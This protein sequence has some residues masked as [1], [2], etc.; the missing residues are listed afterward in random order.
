VKVEQTDCDDVSTVRQVTTVSTEVH[1]ATDMQPLDLTK[2]RVCDTDTETS[3]SG[4]H[5]ALTTS[6]VVA[7]ILLLKGQRY[8]ILPVGGGRWVSRSEYELVSALQKESH[9]RPSQ[10]DDD[11]ELAVVTAVDNGFTSPADSRDDALD[12][13]NANTR[14]VSTCDRQHRDDQTSSM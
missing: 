8:E 2:R 10:T 3:S 14:D 5:A 9:Q 11:D 13:V 4:S 12:D 6:H 7:Q 1:H